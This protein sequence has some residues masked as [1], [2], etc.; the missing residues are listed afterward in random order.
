MSGTDRLRC[1]HCGMPQDRPTLDGSCPHCADIYP[2]TDP[3]PTNAVRCDGCG[4][5]RADGCCETIE[6]GDE[7]V[8]TYC[9]GCREILDENG[10]E[11]GNHEQYTLMEVSA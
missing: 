3:H 6:D 2:G 10:I 9:R 1:H 11:P 4:H 8:G 5:Q 7:I